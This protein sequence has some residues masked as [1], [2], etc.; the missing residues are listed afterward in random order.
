MTDD[1]G[2]SRRGV[3]QHIGA[4]ALLAAAPSVLAAGPVPRLMRHVSRPVVLTFGVRPGG[5]AAP[6]AARPSRTAP[7]GQQPIG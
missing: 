5:S 4:A 1:R 6:L 3:L 2:P 7:T